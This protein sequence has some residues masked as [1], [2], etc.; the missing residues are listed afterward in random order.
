MKNMYLLLAAVTF[1]LTLVFCVIYL[2]KLNKDISEYPS[3]YFDNRTSICYMKDG[4]NVPVI[5]PCTPLVLKLI[6]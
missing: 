2:N 4:L 6:K 1:I 3:Y 5:V